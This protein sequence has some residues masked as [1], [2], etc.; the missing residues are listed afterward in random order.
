MNSQPKHHGAGDSVPPITQS[1][2][3]GQ[4]FVADTPT[5]FS[6]I[7]G[8]CVAV[9]LFD[10]QAGIGGINHIQMPGVPREINDEPMRWAVPGTEDLIEKVLKAGADKTRLRAKIFGGACISTRKVPER[11][12]IGD[13]NISSVLAVLKQHGIRISNSSTGGNVGI[14]VLFDSHNGNVWVKKLVQE[15]GK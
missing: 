3:A 7:L 6:T 13:L 12:R 2:L 1:V 5:R 8:S 14:K 15:T 10:L 11:M 4:V 9:C